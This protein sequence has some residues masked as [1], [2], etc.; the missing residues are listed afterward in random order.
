[1]R[2]HIKAKYMVE[3]RRKWFAK[4]CNN[5]VKD[6]LDYLKCLEWKATFKFE[7]NKQPVKKTDSNKELKNL[8]EK[9]IFTK[10]FNKKPKK[11]VKSNIKNSQIY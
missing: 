3:V 11:N 6:H 10:K 7:V 5:M 4:H 9:T 1:M 2:G 8:R